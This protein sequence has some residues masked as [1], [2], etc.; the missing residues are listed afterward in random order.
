MFILS[1][2]CIIGLLIAITTTIEFCTAQA[3]CQVRGLVSAILLASC[4]IVGVP[5]YILRM[6]FKHNHFVHMFEALL[7][8]GSCLAFLILSRQYKLRK[9]N[10]IIPYHMFAE[11]QFES[12]YNQERQWCR[13]HGYSE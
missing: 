11:D 12:N 1:L 6:F 13:E 5:R 9:R 3:P 2:S 10:D 8:F 4:G 7:M